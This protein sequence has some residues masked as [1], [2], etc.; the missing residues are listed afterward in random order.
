MA[1]DV[2]GIAAS[3]GIG[4]APA[5][6][7]VDP[8]L[9]YDK[10]KVDDTAAEYARVE[11][12]F[13]DS[14]EELTQIKE[15]AK[16]S[17][18]EEELGVFD[19][20]IAILSD[21]EMLGQIKDDIENNHTGAEEAVDKVTTAFADMLAAMTD[22]AYMQERAADVKD[23][24]KRAMSHLLGKQLPNIAGINSPVVIVAHE[25]TPS[26]TSQMDA[27]FV[28]GIVTDL[29]GRTSHAA[30]MSR[31][32]R[33]PAIVG[34]NEIT[35]SVEHGQMMIVDGLNGDA[36]ID[37]SDDQVK[38]YEAKAE[39]FEAER[40]EWAKL[41][42]APSVSKDGKEFEIAANIGTP[43][44]TEDAVK[45]GADGVGLFRSE[46]LYMDN[47]HMPSED[48]QFEAYKKAVVGMNG[49]P[50]VVRTMDIGGD[51]PLDYM[52]LPKEEN[53]FLGYRAIRIC[54]DRPEL[55]KTQLR[56][57]VRASEFGPVSIMF[58]MI[59]TVAELRQAKAIFEEA[60]AEVQKDHPG[61]GDDV[62]IGMMIEIPLAALNAAQLAK[63]VDFFSIGTNDLIQYSFAAD[64]GNE[65]VS[66]LYQP[67][68]PAFLS[69]VKHVIT[70]AH[71]N[72]AKAA[73]C[74][75]MA[76]DEM[77]L[78]LLMG[79]GLDE[80]SMSATSILRTRSM[81]KKLDTKEW[82]GYV[83]EII[84]NCATVEEVQDFV[85]SKLG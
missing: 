70:S 22:N 47:D 65:A 6:L 84:A 25:I 77:A 61:L 29:G 15:N 81:M 62:K 78:P 66:Y 82:A 57:L 11:K 34:S 56:A 63:E 67:L 51:K 68:N 32:L 59:A 38:E 28:K 52:P 19:A 36:I 48:E 18:G 30:I 14:I 31:T 50:V 39:A 85:K 10:V 55:F 53:P 33:I 45:Q 24:A 35:T 2:K 73:M 49:K 79:M 71:E 80:Y 17:L 23:V 20:H 58:P 5:Y 69:L 4:I 83:D 54:L 13:Q 42:D 43:D 75:E 3:D 41:V 64:R 40:A 12:A 9:S 7:L 72:G 21:P 16:D 26:D 76:G 8:D 27:K 74:G 37:P 60:K 44:D 1:K 46:F